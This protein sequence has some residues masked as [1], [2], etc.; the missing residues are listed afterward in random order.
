VDIRSSSDVALTAGAISAGKL[1][2][3]VYHAAGGWFRLI[4][5]PV[6]LPPEI[7]SITATVAANQLTIT[8]PPQYVE[9]RNSTLSNGASVRREI[10]STINLVVSNGSTLGTVANA[11]TR[12]FVLAI[13]NV[14]V[15]EL[16]IVNPTSYGG[17]FNLTETGLITTVAEG[18]AGAADSADVAYST[19]ARA[20]V[21]YRVIGFIDITEAT[22]GV[23]A[24]GP[25]VV[26]GAG[27]NAIEPEAALIA[28]AGGTETDIN[29]GFE[30]RLQ[31]SNFV[32][33]TRRL[34][35]VA[36]CNVNH[37]NASATDVIMNF[38]LIDVTGGGTVVATA[39][40]GSTVV[41]AYSYNGDLFKSI[42]APIVPGRTY[43]LRI[44]LRK[45]VAVGPTYP[46]NMR[47]DTLVQ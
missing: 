35:A 16:A 39:T 28:A 19:A 8:A 4:E 37:N 20:N 44:Q 43:Y 7:H 41:G 34:F 22:A 15:V 13:D 24:T 31:T 46:R 26:Q 33:K 42:S 38:D 2:E 21:A 30:T 40:A 36:S 9:F 12:L 14:G 5:T 47:I 25:T 17:G 11:P 6:T 27:G 29:T 18:G 1:Y 23:W 10:G 32:A 45:T 3:I